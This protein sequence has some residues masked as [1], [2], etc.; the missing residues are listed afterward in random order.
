[1]NETKAGQMAGQFQ[2][3][4]HDT[5]EHANLAYARFVG[6]RAKV[7]TSVTQDI[8]H[9]AVGVS[10]EGGELLDAVKKCWIYNKP[11]SPEVIENLKEEAGDA[12][13]YIQHLCNIL[14]CSMQDLINGN[15][16]KL[17]KRYP[18]GYSDA[19]ALARADKA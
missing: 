19:A 16:D 9:A 7:L 2:A 11:L 13:F 8:L 1:L 12:L 17:C 5:V 14:G 3:F 4:A 15:I 10:G 6:T 18:Q